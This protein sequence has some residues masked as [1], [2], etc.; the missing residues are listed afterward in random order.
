[1]ASNEAPRKQEAP[2]GRGERVLALEDD[3][4]VRETVVAMLEGLGY[5][6]VAVPN[7]RQALA[8]LDAEPM[9]VVLSDVVLTSGMN[10]PEFAEVARKLHP[11]LEIVFMS[12]YPAEAAKHNGV[13]GTDWVLLNKP[14]QM[15]ELARA[16]REALERS[17]PT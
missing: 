2:R 6:V 11:N 4:D 14:F 8:V 1:M 16:L 15:D 3:A 13:L 10:G 9:D 7:A 5:F 12:G 17:E